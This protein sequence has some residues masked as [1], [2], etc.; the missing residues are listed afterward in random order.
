[1]DSANTADAGMG[2]RSYCY[3]CDLEVEA[4]QLPD[5]ELQCPTCD[6]S[7][8][9]R[10][11]IEPATD[12]SSRFSR[13]ALLASALARQRLAPSWLEPLLPRPQS[14]NGSQD[15]APPV[16]AGSDGGVAPTGL[17]LPLLGQLPLFSSGRAAGS[18]TR[19]RHQG[20]IGSEGD[21]PG[22]RH[23]GVICDGCQIRDFTGTRFRCMRCRDF[24]LCASC[25]GERGVLHPSHPFEAIRTPRRTPR[26]TTADF[27]SSAASRAIFAVVEIGLEEMEARSGLNAASVAWWL[28]QD[29][30]LVSADIIAAEEPGWTCP[31]CADGLQ[32]ESES[33]WV[34]KICG[35]KDLC[36]ATEEQPQDEASA[37]VDRGGQLDGHIYHEGCLRRWLVKQ[38][39]CP[40]CRRSPVIPS[41]ELDESQVP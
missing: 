34:V 40:V 8:L 41:A 4:R 38:N 13:E 23:L 16:I 26:R 3:V 22:T 24:D 10:L 31:I 28:A 19:R 15:E 17:P 33:G 18:R 21:G 36:A 30:R 12:D 25:Y 27:M 6:S 1:M 39:S 32:A 14:S 2:V 35:G 7:C 5:L 29:G 37:V 11:S 9:E 20:Q